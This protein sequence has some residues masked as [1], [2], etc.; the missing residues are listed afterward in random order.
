[1]GEGVSGGCV[2]SLFILISL[3]QCERHGAKETAVQRIAVKGILRRF[4]T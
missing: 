2:L 1:M 4:V 3:R